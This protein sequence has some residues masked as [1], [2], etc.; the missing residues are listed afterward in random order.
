M[1]DE[2]MNTLESDSLLNSIAVNN[3]SSAHQFPI[4]GSLDGHFG[5]IHTQSPIPNINIVNSECSPLKK[6]ADTLNQ[7]FKK[8]IED[9][10][11]KI[12]SLPN[13]KEPL[14]H[15]E[16][17]NFGDNFGSNSP[18][19]NDA[20][21]PDLKGI[22]ASNR[23]DDIH[24]IK[25]Q[26][27]LNKKSTNLFERDV[28][29]IQQQIDAQNDTLKIKQA[30]TRALF[31]PIKLQDWYSAY[32]LDQTYHRRRL[33]PSS[34]SNLGRAIKDDDYIRSSRYIGKHPCRTNAQE[35]KVDSSLSDSEAILPYKLPF[36]QRK[37]IK[38]LADSWSKAS[39]SCNETQHTAIVKPC[40]AHICGKQGCR[41]HKNCTLQ[42]SAQ[43]FAELNLPATTNILGERTNN[44]NETNLMPAEIFKTKLM[45]GKQKR[46][47]GGRCAC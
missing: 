39:S 44:V 28:A 23:C 35:S 15:G 30:D 11:D 19:Y 47:F 1:T 36:T 18:K 10:D 25:D 3:A 4:S 31:M 9:L 20:M 14:S 46:I 22:L 34:V 13:G 43:S 26:K 37:S 24:T 27:N 6:Q 41:Y 17:L 33:H 40:K 45:K 38:E 5:S 42:R 29:K 21:K 8:L 16:N 12:S 32:N 7:E 2:Q